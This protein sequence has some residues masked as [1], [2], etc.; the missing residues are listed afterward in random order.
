MGQQ[1]TIWVLGLTL[2]GAGAALV[3]VGRKQ[4]AGTLRRN[5]LVGLRTWETMRSDVAWHA[6]HVATAGLVTVAG[7][8]P[9]VAGSAVLVLQPTDE[10]TIAAIVLGAAAVTLGLVLTAGVRGD[11]IAGRI[12]QGGIED[13][14]RDQE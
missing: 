7:V 11:R 8:V 14:A 3:V 9:V 5:R 6:A 4:K 2:L 1:A 10:G 12:N 13:R